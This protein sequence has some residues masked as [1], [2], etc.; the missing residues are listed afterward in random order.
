M[1]D[2][3]YTVSNTDWR[4]PAE[5]NVEAG[6]N[7][8]E[9]TQ[10]IMTPAEDVGSVDLAVTDLTGPGGA[11]LTAANLEV[12]WEKYILVENKINTNQNYPIGYY[13]D[14]LVPLDRIR[15]AKEDT[16]KAGDNQ[17]LWLTYYIPKGTAAGVYTGQFTLKI[18]SKNYEI[19]VSVTVWDF[20]IPDEVNSQSAAYLRREWLIN[21]EF[22]NTPEMYKKYYD[23]L[24]DYRLSPNDFPVFDRYD[25]Q[26][27]VEYAK[28]SAADVRCSSY[29]LP[30]VTKVTTVDRSM[31]PGESGT[32]TIT[33][34]DLPLVK[35]Y[36]A[37]LA[38]A[39]TKTLDL[40]EKLYCYFSAALDE[41]KFTDCWTAIKYNYVM[42]QQIKGEVV[43]ELSA[44]EGG[45]F[46]ANR[47]D[48]LSG[49]ILKLQNLITTEYEVAGS[50]RPYI[51]TYCP[52]VDYFDTVSQRNIYYTH[53]A[54]AGKSD[55]TW[56]YTCWNPRNPF[57]SQ[58][59]DDALMSTRTMF[60]MQYEYGVK[61]WLYWGTA[62]YA[63]A[64]NFTAMPV[65]PWE[66]VSRFV[67]GVANGDG[68]LTYPGRK[69]GV[70][71]PLPSIRLMAI[72]DGLEEYEY[73]RMLDNG[74]QRA[75]DTYN[76]SG[77]TLESVAGSA[78]RLVYGGVKPNNITSNF[79]T[80][81]RS[82]AEAIVLAAGDAN[83]IL[84][85]DSID[86]TAET[87]NIS[88]YTAAGYTMT[89]WAQSI[90]STAA[91]TGLKF[92]VTAGLTEPKNYLNFTL[93]KISTGESTG[94]SKFIANKTVSI[95]GFET[96]PE[97]NKLGRTTGFGSQQ[98]SNPN[99]ITITHNTLLSAY[100]FGAG[101]AYV[102]VSRA[103]FT[104][105]T[106]A[107]AYK[108]RV[109]LNKSD[110]FPSISMTGVDTIEADVYNAS[111]AEVTLRIMLAS[112]TNTQRVGT[113]TLPS[114]M[115]THISANGIFIL[116]WSNLA[117]V[118]AIYF[119][120]DNPA[121]GTIRY[122][123]DNVFFSLAS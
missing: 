88:V 34:L 112:G 60:W 6:R 54:Q 119:E 89:V 32:E 100:K 116:P 114:G 78:L 107:N 105:E 16:I 108:P 5:I 73:L 10:L 31:F 70:S 19:P 77:L 12:W 1:R 66:D 11:K 103:N 14:G 74:L 38:K 75:R 97:V 118:D 72:R 85:I 3:S 49:R 9:S 93:T 67:G 123:L 51:T 82:I 43:S 39:S 63:V 62:N 50:T 121:A 84:N 117:N 113:F 42:M 53:Q 13:P 24:L 47:K 27:Y 86:S 109:I 76:M 87:A 92:Q 81:R 23:F 110:F 8:Y 104:S 35:S 79:E 41:P 115:W 52:T 56:W 21:G 83:I 48:G 20:T 65:D 59:T 4:G 36:L 96:L 99:H 101:S 37:E 111:G 17:G 98:P 120:T 80:A 44:L 30:Y 46:F 95:T 69:Y 33:S 15:A 25:V 68:Y 94:Y 26:A 90:S 122:Y 18:D 28:I 45:N 61:G 71:G 22:D 57:P 7:E 58:H 40:Y 102:Q 2:Q 106:V 91:G 55:T 64:D 29:A